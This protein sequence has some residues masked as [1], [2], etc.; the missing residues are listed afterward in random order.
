VTRAPRLALAAGVLLAVLVL[1]GVLVLMSR[2]PE[3]A[4]PPPLRGRTLSAEGFVDSIAVGVHFHYTDT[5]YGRA[6]EV[7]QRLRELGVRHVRDGM[8]TPGGP[9]AAGLQ[10]ARAAGVSATLV[11][12]EVTVDPDVAVAD[13]LR[14]L[15]PDHIDA[16]E[17]PNELD[18]SG[19]PG[20][21]ASLRSYMPRLASAVRR[22]APGVPVLGPSLVHEASRWMLPPRLPGLANL[23]PYPG[24][25]PPEG[26]LGAALRGL[27]TAARRRGVVFTETGYHN[28]LR[29][30]T[31]QPPTSEEAAAV[32]LPRLLLAAYG[33]GVRRT[34]VYELLD[35]K[36]N[37]DLSDPEQHFGLLRND[38]SPKPAFQAIRALI[39][40]VSAT[41]GPSHGDPP[42][43]RLRIGASGAVQRLT[44]A[45]RDGSGLVALWRPVSV[46]DRHARRPVEPGALRV[47]L[48]ADGEAR[49]VAVWRP[50]VSPRPVLRRTAARRLT[51]ELA[52]D[53]VLVSFR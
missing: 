19:D 12:P 11:T 42:R 2:G 43:W 52:G 28:A 23:H 35:E 30:T 20:W 45:R 46:W 16:F 39:E 40:A 5:A 37:P 49:D 22:Q 41:P 14:I 44:L 4:A 9:L 24:G 6:R 51:L 29:A 34:V 21:L 36:P 8:P 25:E 33:A 27:R 10:A 38:L 3:D 47:E 50:S 53:A 32:Y 48:L 7:V 18:N 15:G 17:A 13:A 31:G 26:P 1:A